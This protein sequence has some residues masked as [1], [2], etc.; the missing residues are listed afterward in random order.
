MQDKTV[1]GLLKSEKLDWET[2]NWLFDRYDRYFNFG[3][4]VAASEKNHKCDRFFTE[5]DNGLLQ[6]WTSFKCNVWMNPPYGGNTEKWVKKAYD[7]SLKGCLTVALLQAGVDR[8]WFQNYI[9]KPFHVNY[10]CLE[11]RFPFV[12]TKVNCPFPM[13]IAMFYPP[14]LYYGKPTHDEFKEPVLSKFFKL[15]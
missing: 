15:N 5:A 12:G 14:S 8:Q 11:Y 13:M 10:I 6:D 2:P 9:Y 4:D 3:L 7:E 1:R